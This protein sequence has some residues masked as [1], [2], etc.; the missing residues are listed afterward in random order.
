MTIVISTFYRGRVYEVISSGIHSV[1][2]LP[3]YTSEFFGSL[4]SLL[5]ERILQKDS[6]Y[7]MWLLQKCSSIGWI[8][9]IKTM[10]TLYEPDDD[11]GIRYSSFNL[12]LNLTHLQLTMAICDFVR[13][14]P[15]RCSL[16]HAS[17]SYSPDRQVEQLPVVRRVKE[18]YRQSAVHLLNSP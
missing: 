3:T 13:V 5:L 18:R 14:T 11:C 1:F 17:P 9:T 2:I 15:I 6:R 16:V 7:V 12:L 10:T 8:G 4:A